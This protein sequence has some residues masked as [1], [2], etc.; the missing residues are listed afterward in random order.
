M[1]TSPSTHGRFYM[2]TVTFLVED[3]LFRV[4]REPFESQSPV[5]R[6]MFLL[7]V[8]EEGE[9]E[10]LNDSKPI[11][12]E[13]V[14]LGDFEQLMKALF[15]GSLGQGQLPDGSAQWTSVLELATLWEFGVIRKKAI[16]ALEALP[17][18][19]VDRIALA[20]QY[21]IEDWMIPSI[22]AMAQ[23]PEPIGVED[24]QRLGLDVALKI[25]SVRERVSLR[26]VVVNGRAIKMELGVG[27]R[28]PTTKTLDFTS[29]ICT[30]F[31]LPDRSKR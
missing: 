1:T 12:L 15:P 14:K 17:I 6:D 10:G 8:G 3:C 11:R 18:T 25:A 24:V 9:E 16:E 13:G 22:N 20:T 2:T 7:P 23:R 28:D 19:P 26:T 29:I 30:T 4:P 27:P 21:D 5:F 31:N